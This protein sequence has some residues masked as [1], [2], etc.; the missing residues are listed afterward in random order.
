MPTCLKPGNLHFPCLKVT[1]YLLTTQ[2]LAHRATD[3][4]PSFHLAGYLAPKACRH[5]PNFI[6][7]ILLVNL[8]HRSFRLKLLSVVYKEG[9][10]CQM[11]QV[12]KMT[13]DDSRF[14]LINTPH[15]TSHPAHPV[16]VCIV[17]SL[18]Y[19]YLILKYSLQHKQHCCPPGVRL[20]VLCS[21]VHRAKN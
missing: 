8:S 10:S 9:G 11:Q 16:S 1:F 3:D 21:Q 4:R 7:P 14:P 2:Q 19:L 20:H 6:P 5:A 18:L 15:P 12:S 17:Q 13:T